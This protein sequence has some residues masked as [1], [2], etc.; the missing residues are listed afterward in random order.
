MQLPLGRRELRLL[1]HEALM[2]AILE[3][4]E[5]IRWHRDRRFYDRCVANDDH[6]WV[7]LEE[8]P[9][10]TVRS[11]FDRADA[12]EQFYALRGHSNTAVLIADRQPPEAVFNPDRWDDDLNGAAREVMLAVL[13]QIQGAIQQHATVEERTGRTRTW[14]DDRQLYQ[15]TLPEKLNA[16]YYLPPDYL[17]HHGAV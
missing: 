15:A 10:K 11:T 14:H 2:R 4:R 7:M 16:N 8:L 12:Y 1:S 5:A 9:A 3:R 6:I 17:A 13:E